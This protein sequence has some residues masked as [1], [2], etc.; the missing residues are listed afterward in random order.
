MTLFSYWHHYLSSY[1]ESCPLMLRLMQYLQ[2]PIDEH[3]IWSYTLL[4]IDILSGL[5]ELG[6]WRELGTS[7][8]LLIPSSTSSGSQV[9]R[10]DGQRY[11][12]D[13]EHCLLKMIIIGTTETLQ[14]TKWQISILSPETLLKCAP[15]CSNHCQVH[16]S[17]NYGLFFRTYGKVNDRFTNAMLSL[18]YGALYN[19]LEMS[20]VLC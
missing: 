18:K 13:M 16:I 15:K 3:V 11:H 19:A 8:L 6:N 17:R 7:T 12:L 4:H 1:Y 10:T 5:L 14:I 2:M 9:T 20:L